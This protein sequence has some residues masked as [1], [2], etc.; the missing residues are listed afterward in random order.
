MADNYQFQ[1]SFVQALYAYTGAD[2]SSLSFRQGDIIEVLSTLESGWWDGIHCETKVRGWFPSNYVQQ[3]SEEDAL[4]AREQTMGWWDADGNGGR[5]RSGTGSGVEDKLARDF[6]QTSLNSIATGGGGGSTSTGLSRDPSMQDFLSAEDLTSFSNGG[7]IFGEIAAAAQAETESTPLSRTTSKSRRMSSYSGAQSLLDPASESAEEDYWVPKM[8]IHGQLFYYNTTTGETSMDMPID[9]QG[10]GVYV[11]PREFSHEEGTSNG[12]NG[13]LGKVDGDEWSERRTADGQHVYYV[14]L[15]T[16]EQSWDQPRIQPRSSTQPSD[17][18]RPVSVADNA[19]L[20][21]ALTARPGLATPHDDATPKRNGKERD[22]SVC[23]DD[24]ALDTAFVGE[25]SR[26]RKASADVGISQLA[27]STK[28]IERKTSQVRKQAPTAELLGP[29]PPPLITDLGEIVTRS[30]QDLLTAVGIGGASQREQAPDPS[31]AAAKERDRLAELGD[32]VINS[33]RLILHSSGVLEHP[34][35][36]SPIASVSTLNEINGPF[37]LA[38]PLPP[39]VLA[40]LRPS[41]RRLVSTLSKL[42]FSLRAIW[43]LL[44]TTPEDQALEEDD[45]PA[46]PE[47]T[48]R[49]EQIRQQVINE[50]K[51]VAASRFEHETKLRS[52]IMTGAKD[53]GD[54]VLT[55]LTQFQGIVASASNR[56]DGKH[57]PLELLRAPKAPQGSLRTNAAALL[58]PGGGFGGNWRGNGFVSLPTPHSSPNPAAANGGGAST[59]LSY[60]WPMRQISKA[61]ADEIANLTSSIVE[62][63]EQLKTALATE[64]TGSVGVFERATAVLPRLATF[65]T[66][67]EDIDI[68]SAIDF[69][70]SRSHDQP[71][72]RPVSTTTGASTDTEEDPT[73]TLAYRQS[74]IEA[75]PLLAEFETRKQALYDIPP[76]LL[77]ALQSLFLP[78]P[79]HV[80][81]DSPRSASQPIANSPLST[82][83]LPTSFDPATQPLDV[84]DDL[85]SFLPLLCSTLSSLANIAEIQSSA[86][87]NLRSAPLNFRSSLF[88]SRA[89]DNETAPTSVAS[90][91]SRKVES[92][93]F[94]EGPRSRQS[95]ASSAMSSLNSRD[96]VD[97]DFFFSGAVADARATG[98]TSSLPQQFSPATTSTSSLPPVS[99]GTGIIRTQSTFSRS[100]LP[101]NSEAHQ[102]GIGLPPGWD[103]RR[104]SVATTTSS[105]GTGEGARGNSLT[106]LAEIAQT[107][108]LSPTRSSSKNIHKLLGEGAPTD[109]AFEPPKPWYLERDYGDD[110]LSFTME[111]TI[112]GGTLRGLV[113]A[114]TSHEGRVDSSYLSAFLMTYRT[115]CTGH[116]LLDQ[117]VERY[118]TTEPE[119]LE[120]KELQEWES[121]KLRP[122]RARVANLLKAWVREHMDHE[123]TNRDLLLRIREFAMNTM[124]EK[125]QSLQICKSVDERMQGVAP[126]AIGNLAPGP[127]PPPIIPRNLKKIKFLDIEPLELAR[128]LTIMDGRLFQRITPQECLGKAWPKEF[129]SE[130]VNI[131]AMIDMSNAITRWVT[132]TILAQDDQKKRASIVK[133]FIAIA[134]RCL[135]L[136]NFSTLIHIIAGLNSTPIHRLRRT[137]ESVSQK[138][139]VSLG[140]LNNIMRPDKNYKEY[141]DVL[142]KAAPPCVPFLGVYLTDWTFIGDGNPDMLREKPHQINFHKRQK[143]SELIL[144]IKLHQATTYNLSAVPPLATFLQEQLFPR[145][146]DLANDDQRLYEVS[147]QREPRERDDERIARLLGE[148]GFL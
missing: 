134:E 39:P 77:A 133:H 126:R 21:S 102:G 49:R 135:S 146:V 97:S 85:L 18:L 1:P 137:W 10:D 36:V 123:E 17:Q 46:D 72:S 113:I 91:F 132:E 28:A 92:E 82:L 117:L 136:N 116:Q 104:G 111:N 32:N 13:S 71:I 124:L 60:A 74:V 48:L 38:S 88:P 78:N 87:Q 73:S 86:P 114:A 107:S 22:G 67:I 40:Q 128:Q 142:R 66:R 57:L 11:D 101:G 26:E 80:E 20:F 50:R 144:M 47:E 62:S 8:T 44:E 131:S 68:A 120:E 95:H 129:G 6:S 130:A 125:G 139:M 140:V 109:A 106:P 69:Q 43:G 145:N 56:Y 63:A 93:A 7:D 84:V 3:I 76:R 30:L 33:I 35:L 122:I 23:S 147:L 31:K 29:P 100:S 64:E 27:V 96:S 55:F 59:S 110:E 54:Q 14:N 25:S 112:K 79:A 5:P 148:S 9:G 42:T 52:E 58:L 103:R 90:E 45:S 37:P 12:T 83:A 61:L 4:W 75:K 105:A 41:T 2:S 81:E 138:S 53:V 94:H 15:R 141:R 115:F 118:L 65:L 70:L 99:S 121:Q 51:A 108:S 19:S 34:V 24:S 89:D 16:G 143:A 119:G 127:L 98:S